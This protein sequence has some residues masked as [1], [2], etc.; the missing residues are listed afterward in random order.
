MKVESHK[1]TSSEQ[2]LEDVMA[3]NLSTKKE[4]FSL[5]DSRSKKKGID[6]ALEDIKAGRVHPIDDIDE[7]FKQFGLK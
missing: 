4:I 2:A 7:Y 6:E 1:K 5:S 3:S